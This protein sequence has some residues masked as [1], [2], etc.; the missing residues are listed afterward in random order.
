MNEDDYYLLEDYHFGRANDHDRQ[1]S[2]NEE[3]DFAVNIRAMKRRL[4]EANQFFQNDYDSGTLPPPVAPRLFFNDPSRFTVRANNPAQDATNS[5]IKATAFALFKDENRKQEIKTDDGAATIKDVT[6]IFTFRINT[7]FKP[8]HTSTLSEKI[9]FQGRWGPSSHI[10]GAFVSGS[11]KCN[12]FFGEVAE[13]AGVR[14]IYLSNG[15]YADTA[16][17]LNRPDHS[18]DWKR[19]S[20]PKFGALYVFERRSLSGNR[21][22]GHVGFVLSISNKVTLWG[23]SIVKGLS[24]E[25]G[26]LKVRNVAAQDRYGTW[27]AIENETVEANHDDFV[28]NPPVSF[29]E[30]NGSSR[31][32]DDFT[33]F[34]YR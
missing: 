11:R 27:R 15:K 1:D 13:L 17:I 16:A 34:Y 9:S 28:L 5:R 14:A 33:A 6:K 20:S 21:T 31:T 3:P 8:K 29:R 18:S 12:L 19:V 26:G 24:A 30:S 10:G 32:S 4:E 22:G 25:S 7:P 23:G 2:A